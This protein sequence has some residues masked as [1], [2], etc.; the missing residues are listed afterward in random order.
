MAEQ[1]KE[2]TKIAIEKAT[3]L[4]VSDGPKWGQ[5]KDQKSHQL[6]IQNANNVEEVYTV[7]NFAP[8]LPE[9][10]KQGAVVDNLEI[11]KEDYNGSVSYRVRFG[12]K[13]DGGYRGGGY[14]GISPAELNIKRFEAASKVVG[15]AYSYAFEMVKDAPDGDLDKILNMGDKIADAMW[16]KSKA[17]LGGGGE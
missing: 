4:S 16:E 6:V 11:E 15:V 12:D 9:H 14:R 3:I 2:I 8:Q 17:F 5:N 13:K 7:R 10:I 1:E